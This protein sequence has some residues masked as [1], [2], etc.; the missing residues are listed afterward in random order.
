MKL[1]LRQKGSRDVDETDEQNGPQSEIN[2][3][4]TYFSLL[5]LLSIYLLYVVNSDGVV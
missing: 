1:L 5:L 4:F 2:R 3:I